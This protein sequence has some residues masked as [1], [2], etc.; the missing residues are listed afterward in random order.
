MKLVKKKGAAILVGFLLLIVLIWYGG[1]RYLRLQPNTRLLAIVVLLFIGILYLQ[2]KQMQA[3]RGAAKLEHSIKEQADEQKLGMRPEKREEIENLKL[4]LI[5]AIEA[6]KQSKLGRGRSGRSA[7]YALPWYMFIG[8]PAAGK[9]TAII[10]SGLEFPYQSEIKGVGGTRNCD[11]FFSK[12]AILLDTAGRYTTEEEDRAEW[13]AFL[14]MLKKHRSQRP[15]NGVLVGVS[16]TDFMD[17][18]FEDIEWHA[19][20]IR[21]RIDELVERLGTRFPVYLVFTYLMKNSR[22]Y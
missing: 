10:N 5:K 17:A 14:A 1:G 16:I 15:I 21:H 18:S 2:I 9:T 6:L 3:R 20:N 22:F 8:P 4:E 13:H 7:L 19:K 12:S 11:W